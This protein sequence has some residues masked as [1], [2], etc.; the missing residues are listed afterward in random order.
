MCQGSGEVWYGFG[1]EEKVNLIGKLLM[2][3]VKPDTCMLPRPTS[4]SFNFMSFPLP[5]HLFSFFSNP[6][7]ERFGE[8]V[9]T[10]WRRDTGAKDATRK[11]DKIAAMLGTP[12]RQNEHPPPDIHEGCE[13]CRMVEWKARKSYVLCFWRAT[14]AESYRKVSKNDR[15]R[16]TEGRNSQLS[17][18]SLDIQMMKNGGIEDL[19]A[20]ES[21]SAPGCEWLLDTGRIPQQ[22]YQ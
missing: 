18:H 12:L 13:L 17:S 11:W 10:S 19:R 3:L 22:P 4:A 21:S 16:F 2:E 7:S 6:P 5:L 1:I 20:R 9:M 14:G 15:A 8:K